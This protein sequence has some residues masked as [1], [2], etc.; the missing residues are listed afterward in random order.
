MNIGDGTGK[1][2]TKIFLRFIEFIS[3]LTFPEL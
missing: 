3:S 2:T 1:V